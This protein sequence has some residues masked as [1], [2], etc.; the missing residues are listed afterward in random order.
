MP[1]VAASFSTLLLTA[2]KRKTNEMH[3]MHT[4]AAGN[5]AGEAERA[6]LLRG[7]RRSGRC[8]LFACN[9]ANEELRNGN[10]SS[11]GC[12]SLVVACRSG[13]PEKAGP[14]WTGLANSANDKRQPL[15]RWSGAEC[16]AGLLWAFRQESV[17]RNSTSADLE[18]GHRRWGFYGT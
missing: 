11:K 18:A 3:A 16:Q 6:V 12:V 7:G 9:R 10:S 14:G 5:E 2:R 8:L 1:G 17:T 4:D 13:G 15:R